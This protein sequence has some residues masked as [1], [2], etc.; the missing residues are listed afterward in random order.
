MKFLD[1]KTDYAFKKVFGSNEHKPL[2]IKFLNSIITF[3]N[4]A[5]IE[6]LDIIDPYNILTLLVSK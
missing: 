3:A 1:V 5:K 4:R 6:D 2:L